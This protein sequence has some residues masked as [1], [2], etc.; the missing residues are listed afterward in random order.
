MDVL[1]SGGGIAGPAV[2]YWLARDGH[3]TTIV[4]RAPA[5]REGGQAVDFRGAAQLTVIERMGLLPAIRRAAT[6]PHP[7]TIVDA[8]GRR[9]SRLPSEAFGG[10]VEI[11]RGDLCRILYEA[12][13][14]MTDYAFDDT[15]TAMADTGDGVHV[16]FQ[17]APPRTFDLVVGADGLHSAVR[18]LAFGETRIDHL[19]MCSAIFSVP[20]EHPGLMYS[21]P[22]RCATI[23]GTR[24]S[25][26]FAAEPVTI[27]G[28]EAQKALVAEAFAGVGWKVPELLAAMWRAPDFY[29]DAASQVH[30]DR[31]SAGR[32]VLLG[33]A[34]YCPGPGGMGTGLAVVGAYVLAT[35]LAGA[36]H[37][38]AFAAYEARMRPYVAVCQKQAQGADRFL[39]PAKRSQIWARNQ[40]FKLLSALPGKNLIRAMTAKAANAITL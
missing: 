2:A 26:G 40:T 10:D 1:I 22:G 20:D 32:V 33:D 14:N 19:G 9:L 21:V 12:T 3:R 4:E 25:L 18:D 13:R 38:T 24:A 5:L 34:G 29:F 28:A 37:R 27:R 7:I 31:Y 11:L 23:I 35:E 16:T 15:V 36:D 17:N 30:L 6:G 39:V 8:G